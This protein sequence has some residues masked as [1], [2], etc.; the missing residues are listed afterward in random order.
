[1]TAYT[2][3][4]NTSRVGVLDRSADRRTENRVTLRPAFVELWKEISET[5]RGPAQD[6]CHVATG[7]TCPHGF[8][9]WALVLGLA[10]PS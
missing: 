3:S 7:G 10:V 1:M 5:R 2:V 8:R 6:G 4:E 9:S